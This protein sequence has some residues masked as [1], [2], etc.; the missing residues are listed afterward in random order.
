M[1]S[2]AKDR[3]HRRGAV[4]DER[5]LAAT[6]DVIAET[7]SFAIRIDDV[8]RTAGVNKTTIYRR[9]PTRDDLVLKAILTHAAIAIPLPDTGAL[10]GDLRA[11]CEL[12]RATI[13]SPLGCALLSAGGELPADL[14]NLRQQ[15]WRERLMT[16]TE[17]FSRAAKR[18][19]C[20]VPSDPEEVIELMVA[21]LHFRARQ[22]NRELTDAFLDVQVT[23]ALAAL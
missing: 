1:T 21:P 7:G 17:L 2:G 12:V 11:L 16:A 20:V 13:T 5:V 23:R 9:Y 18:G 15:F 10:E 19:E 22:M 8:A 3:S 14:Q 6:I 4:V